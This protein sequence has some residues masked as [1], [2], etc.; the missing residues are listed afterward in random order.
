[1]LLRIWKV[2]LVPGK[3]R[4]LEVFANTIS[5]PMFKRQPGCLAVFFTKS[6]AQCATVTLWSSPEAVEE[7]ERS[8]DYRDVVTQIEHSGIIGSNHVTEVY[9]VYGGYASDQLDSGLVELGHALQTHK[10]S[11]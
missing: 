7:M 11:S 9:T 4:E 6:D 5:L 1:M 2:D 3:A 8:N 10:I